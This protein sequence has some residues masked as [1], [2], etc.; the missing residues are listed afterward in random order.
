M[1]EWSQRE[2]PNI[3]N[4]KVLATGRES[5]GFQSINKISYRA[6]ASNASRELSLR[7]QRDV[8]NL[9]VLATGRESSE[10]GDSSQNRISARF[11]Q[12]SQFDRLR[13]LMRELK[14][15]NDR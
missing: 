9:K 11:T 12:Q 8:D 5:G 2:Q 7:E 1:G 4:L 14:Q 13:S 3:D 15:P 10:S 6:R